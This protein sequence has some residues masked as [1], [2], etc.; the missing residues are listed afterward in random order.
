MFLRDY[1]N[2][3]QRPSQRFSK[4]AVSAFRISGR[5]LPVLRHAIPTSVKDYTFVRGRM[6]P[7][8]L[9]IFTSV[10]DR[11]SLHSQPESNAFFAGR[12]G[13]GHYKRRKEGKRAVKPFPDNAVLK[14]LC[15]TYLPQ[16]YTIST[17]QTKKTGFFTLIFIRSL[18]SFGKKPYICPF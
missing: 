5:G 15:G 3:S 4:T 6:L 8:F 1:R 13:K 18:C 14:A 11:Y 17:K 10:H 9:T 7:H 16:M 12:R 2:V